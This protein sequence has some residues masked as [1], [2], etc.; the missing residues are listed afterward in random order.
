MLQPGFMVQFFL[1][2]W[3]VLRFLPFPKR[4]RPRNPRLEATTRR[5]QTPPTTAALA[6]CRPV[7]LDHPPPPVAS[8]GQC[9]AHCQ[10][11]HRRRMAPRSLSPLLALAVSAA[12]WQT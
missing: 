5:A 7:V 2:V 1:A 12:R 6:L 10:T 9:P 11:R 4:Y 3:G 8:L